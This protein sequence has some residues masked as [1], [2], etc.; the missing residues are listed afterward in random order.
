VI[1]KLISNEEWTSEPAISTATSCLRHFYPTD[2]PKI[3]E[4]ALEAAAEHLNN[5]KRGTTKKPS[6]IPASA[7]EEAA[8][9]IYY[10]CVSVPEWEVQDT[11]YRG[12]FREDARAV[13][14]AVAL[15]LQ[16]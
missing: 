9:A 14:Q 11:A 4:Q 15:R 1:N 8:K 13:L 5:V 7:I 6:V 16:A 2:T 12:L 3:A 10:N